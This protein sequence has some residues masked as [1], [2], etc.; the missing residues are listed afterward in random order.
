MFSSDGDSFENKSSRSS[1]FPRSQQ[2]DENNSNR[3]GEI[4]IDSPFTSDEI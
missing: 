2:T 4:S 1:V 3:D